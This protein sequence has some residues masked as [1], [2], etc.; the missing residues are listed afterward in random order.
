VEQLLGFQT[1]DGGFST[2]PP[3]A[4]GAAYASW[5][6]SHPD[7]TPVA[8]RALV[9]H[10]ARPDVAAALALAIERRAADRAADGR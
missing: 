7:V 6:V 9:R 10:R 2:F 1:L 4:R 5:S 3:N 8:V